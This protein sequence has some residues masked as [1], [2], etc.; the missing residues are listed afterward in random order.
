MAVAT[1]LFLILAAAHVGDPDAAG[2]PLS[3]FREERPLVG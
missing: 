3:L 2:R 1:T